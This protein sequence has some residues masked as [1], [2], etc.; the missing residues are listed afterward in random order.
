MTL[1]RAFTRL[2]CSVMLW[3][4]AASAQLLSF[5]QILDRP[6][7]PQPDQRLPYGDDPN[8]VGEL[9]L[10]KT[11]GPHP[12]VLMIHGGCWLASLPGPELLAFQADA[13]RTAGVAVWSISYR[14][15]DQPGGGYPGTFLDVAR[16]TDKLRE[17]TET[18]P[19]DLNRLV[20]TGH[21]AGGHLALWA[22]TRQN[23][24]AA[25]P[26]KVASPLPIHAVVGVAGVPDLAFASRQGLCNKSVDRLVG[27]D[28]RDARS[29]ATWADISPITLLP[30]RVKQTVLIHG[31]YDVI[32]P[33][34]HG[35]GYRLRAAALG[36]TVEI[37]N[38]D[39]AGHFE[40][41]APWTP[42]GRQVVERIVQAA[43]AGR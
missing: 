18:H 19:L 35:Y 30:L 34:A 36:E 20:A 10:P 8:Q 43:R 26:L 23:I 25:S 11:K 2:L 21:S 12:V 24:D 39:D 37:V 5:Q 16:G 3:A 32:V 33:P 41:I 1:R 27:L 14:R 4:S 22:A 13:L 40:L 28:S 6:D 29:P 38:L 17:L 15:A 31:V 42:A 9:W 7:R